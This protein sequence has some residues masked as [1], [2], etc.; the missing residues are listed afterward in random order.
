MGG[1][2]IAA[3]VCLPLPHFANIP[4]WALKL[5]SSCGRLPPLAPFCCLRFVQSRREK[6]SVR[7]DP[8]GANEVFLFY[9]FL[10]SGIM[11]PLSWFDSIRF[12]YT[13]EAAGV[14]DE[15]EEEF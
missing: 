2:I 12:F 4:P 10:N 1:F 3:F 5:L 11:T 13:R 15:E 6:E 14:E 9:F 8:I 7:E